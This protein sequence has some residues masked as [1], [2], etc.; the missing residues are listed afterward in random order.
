MTLVEFAMER[1]TRKIEMKIAGVT[2][3]AESRI[4][5]LTL[6]IDRA[7]QQQVMPMFVPRFTGMSTDQYLFRMPIERKDQPHAQP[8]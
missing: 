6:V 5:L 3:D 8:E 7:M 4:A 2:S 1:V